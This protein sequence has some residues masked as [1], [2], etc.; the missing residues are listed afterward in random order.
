MR[1]I[2]YSRIL[3]IIISV[4]FLFTSYTS[5]SANNQEGTDTEFEIQNEIMN[6]NEFETFQSDELLQVKKEQQISRLKNMNVELVELALE[7]SQLGD[8]KLHKEIENVKNELII[9]TN[10]IFP[11]DEPEKLDLSEMGS[12]QEN[13]LER[14]LILEKKYVEVIANY[15]KKINSLTTSSIRST[16]FGKTGDKQTIQAGAKALVTLRTIDTRTGVEVEVVNLNGKVIESQLLTE[17]SDTPTFVWST[18]PNISPGTYA[19]LFKYPGTNYTEDKFEIYIASPPP[20]LDIQMDTEVDVQLSGGEYQ[21]YRFTPP[22]SNIYSFSSESYDRLNLYED[23]E[24]NILV[25]SQEDINRGST[26]IVAYLEANE[27][28]F[29]QIES[30]TNDGLKSSIEVA[31]YVKPT[32]LEI[33]QS[34]DIDIP[35]SG[36]QEFEI[37]PVSAGTYRIYT[38][39]AGNRDT[40]EE[41][42]TVLSLYNQ[43]Y[44][45]VLLDWN[46]DY[47]R[48]DGERTVFSQ[49]EWN[50]INDNWCYYA[51]VAGYNNQA[52]QASIKVEK[53]QNVFETATLNNPQDISLKIHEAAFYVFTPSESGEY[54]LFTSPYGAGSEMNDTFMQIYG[55]SDLHG[56]LVEN[57][58]FYDKENGV[59]T[60]FSSIT[61]E[62]REGQN[63]YI[64]LRPYERYYAFHARF[65][66]TL[67]Q[68][69]DKY[70]PNDTPSSA[71]PLYLDTDT[72]YKALIT[73]SSDIDYFKFSLK[74]A[75]SY[76]INLS[77]P[78]HLNYNLTLYKINN[79][80]LSEINRGV[81]IS[82]GR[83][84]DFL[85]EKDRVY[86]IKVNSLDGSSSK[87]DYYGFQISSN[88]WKVQYT[89]NEAGQIVRAIFS[90]EL[91]NYI[92]TYIYDVNGNLI[93]QNLIRTSGIN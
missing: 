58:D 89:Y 79:G 21:L 72:E 66:I 93:K 73:S 23:A 38:D 40:G 44:G 4:S 83:R 34:M 26:Q 31:K 45:S 54:T 42:D 6:V 8:V 86:V 63:Y 22:K 33:G 67:K 62:M 16:S 50:M 3:C 37:C 60:N 48:L 43:P 7:V 1:K 25:Q 68:G 20:L 35:A 88:K 71:Y 69:Y 28:Y 59:H 12:F 91:N 10:L 47:Y 41:S 18:P 11:Q 53:L 32:R 74:E 5:I 39:Y 76:S 64:V 78:S 24:L 15:E 30:A 29:I 51:S 46:N 49:I 80:I 17:P 77:Y 90:S 14:G 57:D 19:I 70:E 75:G 36:Y 85:A 55:Y 87:V 92:I 61:M 2:E 13:Q 56:L 27:S 52:V 9:E 81:E 84:I 82:K 65:T